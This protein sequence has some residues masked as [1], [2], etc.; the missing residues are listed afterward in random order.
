MSASIR[1]HFVSNGIFFIAVFAKI[2]NPGTYPG[3]ISCYKNGNSITCPDWRKHADATV[4]LLLKY[5]L[6]RKD[7]KFFG[8]RQFFL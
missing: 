4:D 3:P 7:V 6:M 1:L 8:S 2:K 5:S